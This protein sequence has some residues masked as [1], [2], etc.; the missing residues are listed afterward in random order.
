PFFPVGR[1]TASGWSLAGGVTKGQPGTPMV[2]EWKSRLPAAWMITAAFCFAAMGSLAH[3]VGPRCD[4]LLIPLIRIV[5][6]LGFSWG[7]AWTG[8]G[9][10]VLWK[11]RT[12]GVRRVAGPITLVSSF[13]S[14]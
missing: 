8:R 7:L 3:S 1:G 6:T 5:C 12:L 2:A 9:R 14:F 13:S 4:W 11:P 10:L